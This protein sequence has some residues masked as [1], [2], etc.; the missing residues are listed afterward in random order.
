MLV[1]QRLILAVEVGPSTQLI[2]Y[3]DHVA[4]KIASG[5]KL[6]TKQQC[7]IEFLWMEKNCTH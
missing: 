4:G 7:A 3:S 5:M 2:A 1:Y 6:L